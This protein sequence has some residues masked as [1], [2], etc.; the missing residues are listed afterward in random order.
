[1]TYGSEYDPDGDGNGAAAAGKWVQ[2]NG[3]A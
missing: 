2:I 3:T 1:M